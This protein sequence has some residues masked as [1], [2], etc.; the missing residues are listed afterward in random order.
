VEESSV[1]YTFSREKTSFPNGSAFYA[2]DTAEK[3]YPQVMNPGI[4]I[5][6]YIVRELF[7]LLNHI[8]IKKV[9]T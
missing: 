7:F 4:W 2:N 1:S 8:L 6:C 3:V 9:V 5:K